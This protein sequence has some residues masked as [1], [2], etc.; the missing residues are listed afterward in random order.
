MP[1]IVTVPHTDPGLRQS[2]EPCDKTSHRLQIHGFG[3]VINRK[4]I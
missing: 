3:Q 4:S 1:M 2:V